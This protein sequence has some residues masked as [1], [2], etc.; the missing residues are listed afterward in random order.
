MTHVAV[1]EAGCEA[2][3]RGVST[4]F[5]LQPSELNGWSFLLP[6]TVRAVR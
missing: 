5:G 4:A 2:N 3:C 6:H 1:H